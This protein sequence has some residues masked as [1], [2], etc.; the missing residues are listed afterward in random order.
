MACQLAIVIG[1]KG[2]VKTDMLDLSS[3][4]AGQDVV[5]EVV[6]AYEGGWGWLAVQK[7]EIGSTVG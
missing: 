6:D 7:I 4:F 2:S 1:N 5:F 3:A